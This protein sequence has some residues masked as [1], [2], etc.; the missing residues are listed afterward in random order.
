MRPGNRHGKRRPQEWSAPQE[1]VD[2]LAVAA[3]F[4]QVA[5]Q[6]N[7]T[8]VK[9]Q[10][11]SH[12]G[13]NTTSLIS[14][15]NEIQTEEPCVD[16]S[17]QQVP[18][19]DI[20]ERE[21]DKENEDQSSSDDDSEVDLTEALARMNNDED[22]EAMGSRRKSNKNKETGTNPPKTE[23]EVDPYQ[24]PVSELESKFQISLSVDKE[25]DSLIK[26]QSS[27]QTSNHIS[28]QVQFCPVSRF[29][30]LCIFWMCTL[31]LAL[32]S[33]A[34]FIHVSIDKGWQSQMPHGGRQNYCR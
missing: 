9:Q 24:T 2:D 15:E 3:S 32:F 14:D 4:A 12:D 6:P 1:V 27:S 8:D 26:E 29:A 25:L 13:G 16:S 33:C 20:S 5:T 23:N 34:A 17:P 11:P 21:D 22:D 19:T 7:A 31:H 18:A 30:G 10:E 28:G